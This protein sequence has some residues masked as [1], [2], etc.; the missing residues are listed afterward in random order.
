MERRIGGRIRLSLPA[1]LT[2]RWWRA[3]HHRFAGEVEEMQGFV[4]Y[5]RTVRE[6]VREI[7]KQLTAAPPTRPEPPGT[8]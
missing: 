6:V 3:G 4:A 2:V 5:G 8:A 7:L 1:R